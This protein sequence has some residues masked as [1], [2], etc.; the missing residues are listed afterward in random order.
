M[1]GPVSQLFTSSKKQEEGSRLST[2]QKARALK[3]RTPSRL[4]R[5]HLLASLG[6][7]LGTNAGA[8]SIICFLCKSGRHR[9]RLEEEILSAV[10]GPASEANWASTR[11]GGRPMF[12]SG[13][14][15][16]SQSPITAGPPGP[17]RAPVSVTAYCRHA[18]GRLSQSWTGGRAMLDTHDTMNDGL[19]G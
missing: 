11:I 16:Y 6:C 2:A 9:P 3:C 1:S 4:A 17:T 8:N 14:A 5:S 15:A 10:G 7:A 12:E 18:P 13:V 19:S